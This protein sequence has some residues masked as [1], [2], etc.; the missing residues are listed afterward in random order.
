M[1]E[2]RDPKEGGNGGAERRCKRTKLGRRLEANEV[3]YYATDSMK[4][5]KQTKTEVLYPVYEF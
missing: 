2:W 4:N 5:Q 3:M 1:H